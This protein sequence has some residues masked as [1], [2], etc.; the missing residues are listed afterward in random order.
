M[1]KDPTR[2]TL[3]DI[4]NIV[5]TG[6]SEDLH[7]E[8][9]SGLAL[10]P[11]GQPT[12][13]LTKDISAFANSDGGVIIY[14]VAEQDGAAVRFEPVAE[15]KASKDWLEQVIHSR[16]HPIVDGLRIREFSHSSGT[17]RIVLVIIP[18]SFRGPHQA[19]D[20]RYYKRYESRA[21]PMEDYEI[22]DVLTRRGSPD[23]S[24]DIYIRRH[25]ARI[26][27]FDLGIVDGPTR[28][29]IEINMELMNEGDGEI[30]QAL[31]TLVFEETLVG[32][33]DRYPF[34]LRPLEM[35]NGRS[36]NRVAFA[37]VKW[38]ES[39]GLSVYRG[40]STRLFDEDIPIHFTAQTLQK[41]PPPFIIWEVR[42][43]G[44]DVS[45]GMVRIQLKDDSLILVKQDPPDT[46]P[47]VQKA[48]RR[49]LT[50]PDLSFE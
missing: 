23:P 12:N 3:A 16:I 38:R 30:S 21:V 37:Q 41:S 28:H 20:K 29:S 14:G 15:P 43:P 22:R 7:F 13:E 32:A 46:G 5:R 27:A 11:G 18:Q 39:R 8:I 1:S 25:R 4:E 49:F 9:K 19:G 47:F 10:S 40:V 24:L 31:V 36:R 6:R 2:W 33:P 17:G 42:A 45:R 26:D 34:E 50:K 48:S 35:L 44:C